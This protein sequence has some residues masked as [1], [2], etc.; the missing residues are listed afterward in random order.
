[1]IT[2]DMTIGEIV[3]QYPQTLK[4]FEQY[5]L[6]CF[7]CQIADFEALEHGANVHKLD[8]DELLEVLNRSTGN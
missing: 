1:M 2:K 5:G 3:R 8:V 4:V 7:E 6:E